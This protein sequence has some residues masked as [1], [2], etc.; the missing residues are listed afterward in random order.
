MEE[1]SDMQFQRPDF[2]GYFDDTTTVVNSIPCLSN[3]VDHASL[4]SKDAFRVRKGQLETERSSK[5]R[6]RALLAGC[7]VTVC[8]LAACN[9]K[10]AARPEA[11]SESG[12]DKTTAV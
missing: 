8:F 5:R 7:V 6:R 9:T 2:I 11:S 4:D 3:R 10:E 1:M 12:P